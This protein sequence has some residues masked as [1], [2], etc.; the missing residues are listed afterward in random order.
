MLSRSTAALLIAIAGSLPTQAADEPQQAPVQSRPAADSP[1]VAPSYLPATAAAEPAKESAAEA[2]AADSAPTPPATVAQPATATPQPAA[3]ATAV[4]VPDHQDGEP[5][6][7]TPPAADTSPVKAPGAPERARV[8]APE[9]VVDTFDPIVIGARA[10]LAAGNAGRDAKDKA[11]LAALKDYYDEADATP[12]WTRPGGLT[13]RA[14]AALAALLRADQHGLDASAYDLPAKPGSDAL[15]QTLVEAELAIGLAVLKYA[16]D[17]RGGRID[18]PSLSANFDMR[19]RLYEPKSVLEAVAA[20]PAADSYLEGLHPKHTGFTGLR[21][22]LADLRSKPDADASAIRRVVVNMERWRWLP[23]DL[24][25][26]HVWDNV[27]EQHTQVLHDGKVVLKERIVVGKPKTP[28]PIFSAPM[29]FVIFQPS[30]GVPEGIKTNEIGPML[31]RAQANSSGGWFFGDDGGASRA[32]RRH[33][34][35]VFRGGREVNPDQVNWSSVDVRQ[36]HFTQP[37][38]ARNVL[39]VVKFRFPNKFDVYMHD[40]S[41]RHLF[42]KAQRAFSHGCMR[43]QN[44]LKLAETILAYDK[45]WGPEKIAAMARRSGTTDITLDKNVP[46]HIVYFTAVANKEGQLQT[47]PD[48]YGVDGRVASALAGRS[49]TL[50][51][52]KAAPEP[53]AA[54]AAP[55]KRKPAAKAKTPVKTVKKSGGA[56]FDP[57]SILSA[58]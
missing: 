18:P 52:T 47:Y 36:F 57:F 54:A 19:P 10:R 33:D 51:S 3:S 45:G 35:R 16:R 31:R 40:T 23:D 56:P 5:D 9:A 21:A 39:G 43:V 46:V 49:V 32:L 25:A 2:P 17:A 11:H 53:V 14:D 15:T 20:A 22:A 50:A 29:R 6:P 28:T 38:S 37:P 58:N 48:I 4:T 1:V 42:G 34:L 8:A 26:F 27:P 30:W 55:P 44:P 7:L 24:G 13:P 41:E 12:I